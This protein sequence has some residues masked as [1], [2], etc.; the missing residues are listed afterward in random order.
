MKA[1]APNKKLGQHYL[2]D[3]RVIER[4]VNAMEPWPDEAFIEIG[5]GPGALT[6]P[7]LQAGV[8]LTVVEKDARFLD[9]L[10]HLQA[11]YQNRL[12][13]IHTDALHANWQHL[14]A[15]YKKPHVVGNLPYNV[16]TEILCNLLDYAPNIG[17]L[18]FMLQKEVVDRILAQPGNKQWG[19]LGVLCDVL[20]ERRK[21]FDVSPGAFSPPPKVFSSI[22]QLDPLPYPRFG[23]N[24]LALGK[25]LR[26]AF[27]QR[28]KMLRGILKDY[29]S[30]QDFLALGIEPTARAETLTTQ[31]LC[32]LSKVFE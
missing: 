15:G 17:R 14:T 16:G 29:V 23:V 26:L 30:E 2:H 19:R 8:K 31:Q 7:L 3:T 25:L 5:P 10:N 1:P 18:T 6:E 20:C 9:H 27:G 28:R 24:R 4:L 11:V 22:V 32:A 12:E 21:L 13:I